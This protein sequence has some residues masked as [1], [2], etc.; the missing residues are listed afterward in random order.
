MPKTRNYHD[1]L[2]KSLK[3]PEEAAAY[4]QAIL[5]EKAPEPELLL[6]VLRDVVKAQCEISKMAQ[7]DRQNWEKLQELLKA[8]GAEE[9]YRFI[10]L[11][12]T[13]KLKTEITVSEGSHLNHINLVNNK[14]SQYTLDELLAG[15][16]E[17][18]E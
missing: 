16:I 11:L 15:E 14:K 1:Y 9:V 17:S 10:A 6:M 8:S 13:L 5:E 7:E 4:I 12:K 3:Q 2:I 18:S